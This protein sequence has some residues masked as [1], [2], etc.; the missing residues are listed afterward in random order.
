MIWPENLN[1]LSAFVKFV[2]IL[3]FRAAQ[4]LDY[5]FDQQFVFTL[6]FQM[7]LSELP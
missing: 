5:Y 2:Q 4:Y 3:A 1:S 6:S 7:W